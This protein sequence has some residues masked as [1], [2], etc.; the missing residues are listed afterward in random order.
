MIANGGGGGVGERAEGA[1][2]SSGVKRCERE[3]KKGNRP[4]YRSGRTG[5]YGRNETAFL[6]PPSDY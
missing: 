6:K 3:R 4:F 2:E 1:E 5:V